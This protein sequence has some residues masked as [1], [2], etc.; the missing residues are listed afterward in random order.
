MTFRSRLYLGSVVHRRLRPH[1]HRLRYRIFW[2]VLDL[3]EIDG[4][5][6]GL[7][8][9]S[10]KRFSVVSFRDADH[11][12]GSATPLRDQVERHL[13]A[14]GIDT[15]G[16][17]IELLCM[18]RIFGYGFNPLSVYFCYRDDRSLAAIIYEV[19][20][21]FHERHSYL[22]PTD[23]DDASTR[24]GDRGFDQ[25]CDKVLYVS[26]FL[27][28]D[29]TYA[30]R[31][32][33]PAERVEVAIHGSDQQGL[34]IAAALVGERRALTDRNL[35]RVLLAYPLLTLKVIVAIHWHA[36]RM[37]LKGFAVRTHPPAPSNPVT[38][39]DPRSVLR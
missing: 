24:T 12:D 23:Q 25:Q 32:E 33:P 39:V 38:I 26:P 14:A 1:R 13:A 27:D 4:L 9:F 31:V 28:M 5:S 3:D 21:T 36:L 6:R 10:R 20:N 8:L 15:K 35:V 2:M 34:L 19:H 30:F 37:V 17:R 7:W 16:G 22:I 18:P 11:G 29:M